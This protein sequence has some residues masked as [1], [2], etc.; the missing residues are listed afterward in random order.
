M[1]FPLREEIASSDLGTSTM[2]LLVLA[3]GHGKQFQSH[4]CVQHLYNLSEFK[5]NCKKQDKM[6]ARYFP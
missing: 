5:A 1:G 6:L 4:P 2:G 3:V